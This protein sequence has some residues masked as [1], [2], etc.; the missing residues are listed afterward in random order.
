[1]NSL[2]SVDAAVLPRKI[3]A[4]FDSRLEKTFF[5]VKIEP[6]IFSAVV[7][8]NNV[9]ENGEVKDFVT[10]LADSIQLVNLSRALLT[11]QHRAIQ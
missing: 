2:I 6:R 5:V 11:Y 3:V 4:I 8:P 1:M 9:T 10:R 7:L